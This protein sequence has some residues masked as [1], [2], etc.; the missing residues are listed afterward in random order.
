MS[1]DKSYRE[2]KHIQNTKATFHSETLAPLKNPDGSKGKPR[3]SVEPLVYIQG[4]GWE[5]VDVFEKGNEFAIAFYNY[6]KMKE[7]FGYEHTGL[8]SDEIKTKL[9][10]LWGEKIG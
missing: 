6:I 7:F 1:E 8:S 9:E 10:N 5:I 3:F 2:H 4:V